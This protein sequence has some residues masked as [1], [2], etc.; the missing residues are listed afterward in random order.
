M[1]SV[2][3]VAAYGKLKSERELETIPKDKAPHLQW[4]EKGVI[5]L[6]NINFKYA[7]NYPYVLKLVSLKVKSCEKVNCCAIV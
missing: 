6:N 4:P 2:E 7:D 3:R 1:V 5:E